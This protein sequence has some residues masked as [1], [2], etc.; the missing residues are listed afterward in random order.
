MVQVER[1]CEAMS[2]LLLASLS[3]GTVCWV[4]CAFGDQSSRAE[5]RLVYERATNTF[6]RAF[7][8][9][10]SEAAS[11]ELPFRLAPIIVQQ[12]VL[13][14]P[15]E[16]ET[17]ARPGRLELSTAGKT[18]VTPLPTVYWSM[19]VAVISGKPRAR[20]T[21]IWFYNVPEGSSPGTELPFQGVRLTLNENGNPVLWEI[22]A[23]PSGFDVVFAADSLERASE[24]QYGKTD[25]HRKFALEQ[26]VSQAPST[27]VARIIDDGPVPMG[28]ILYLTAPH[29]SVSTLICRCMPSQAKDV[30][31]TS[32]YEL[33][34]IQDSTAYSLSAGL[35]TMLALPKRFLP[36][37]KDGERALDNV[38]R[39][40]GGW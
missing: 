3:I 4:T 11:K 33:V 20:L 31:G 36:G 1:I 35:R 40:A 5:P 15:E 9:K 29:H 19:N 22:L 34:E 39:L 10:P 18:V 30:L 32:T 26:P 2:L 25:A 28:P 17:R 8:Y 37:E 38:L 23:D 21:Y 7:I 16:Q 27:I 24:K 6:A 13:N 12:A 14:P